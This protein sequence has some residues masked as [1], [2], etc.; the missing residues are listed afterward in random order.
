M[1]KVVSSKTSDGIW[2]NHFSSLQKQKYPLILFV[3]I[4]FF[5]LC[6]YIYF[7]HW[8]DPTVVV[9]Y[10]FIM[11]IY[12]LLLQKLRRD[13]VFSTDRYVVLVYGRHAVLGF[14]KGLI[15]ESTRKDWYLMGFFWWSLKS[16][17]AWCRFCR[18]RDLDRT[19]GKS[20]KKPMAQPS[21]EEQVDEF[22]KE[23]EKK[24]ER[25]STE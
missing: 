6:L 22:L 21:V 3:S 5:L 18:V 17:K 12:I 24:D 8:S 4:C 11:P 15:D 2:N 23:I 16:P 9:L 14:L 25:Y 20:I 19:M 1:T 10:F 7:L 13:C